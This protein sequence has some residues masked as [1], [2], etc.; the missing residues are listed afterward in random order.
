MNKKILITGGSG[1]VGKP[2]TRSLLQKGYS[3]H[4]LS[5]DPQLH[6][7]PRITVFKWDVLKKEIDQ[8]CIN[9]V[10]AII[11]LAGESIAEKR[12]TDQRKKQIIESRTDSIGLIYDL[13][14]NNPHHQVKTLISASAIGFYGDRGDELLSEESSPGT[15]F[16]SAAC[17]EWEKA[18]DDG[19]QLGLRII[20]FRT[21]VVLTDAGGAL[22]EIAKPI[23]MGLG[24]ALGSGNQWISWIHIQDVIKMY[25]FALE[26]I[27][28]R[29]TYNMTSPNPVTNSEITRTLAHIF[30][31]KL[32]L[33]NVPA[34]ALKL[35][36]GELSSLVLDS[37][38][39]SS[40]KIER[41]GFTFDFPEIKKALVDIYGD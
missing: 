12:W 34:F 6:G 7:N 5:R 9:G 38:K 41:E 39:V 20:K 18:V 36:L 37:A 40:S 17:L 14:K 25:A 22:P 19:A 27:R 33:P 3:I 4:H 32:W 30:N 2:L 31:K 15:G 10:D 8:D 23:K 11:H 26:N 35:A 21:G 28:L 29:G 13:L 1:V 24:A 16:L